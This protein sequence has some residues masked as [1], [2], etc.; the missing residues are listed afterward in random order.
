MGV[1][2]LRIGKKLEE[3]VLSDL[4]EFNYST[5]TEYFRQ[6]I[7]ELHQKLRTEK[8]IAQ[9]ARN[10]GFAKRM[11]IKEPTEEGYERAREEVGREILE[12][13]KAKSLPAGKP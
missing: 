11:G 8:A 1:V 5:K 4:R 2:T 10:K 6:A 7:R 12:K 9:L 13:F 3:T